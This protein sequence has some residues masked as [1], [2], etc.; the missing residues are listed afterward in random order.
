MV[1]GLSARVDLAPD[2]AADIQR[3]RFGKLLI[4]SSEAAQ[5][6]ADRAHMRLGSGS[7]SGILGGLVSA[8]MSR[9]ALNVTVDSLIQGQHIEC[10]DMDELL[11]AEEAIRNACETLRAY[12]DVATTF[13]GSEEVIEYKSQAAAR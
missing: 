12:L 11:G 9:I 7:A 1:F 5:K 10:K 4:Y 13:H 8:A 2:E 6:H 3:Y